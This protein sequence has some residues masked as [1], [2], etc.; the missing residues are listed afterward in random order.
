MVRGEASAFLESNVGCFAASA[1]KGGNGRVTCKC[2]AT[3]PSLRSYTTRACLS[4][5]NLHVRMETIPKDRHLRDARD[6]CFVS[7]CFC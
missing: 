7:C 1:G 2:C 4:L 3:V 5:S 6:L